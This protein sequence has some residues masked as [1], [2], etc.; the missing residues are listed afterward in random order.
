M[1][2]SWS[3]RHLCTKD[4]I[5]VTLQ[6]RIGML[7]FMAT[8]DDNCV[9]NLGLWDQAFALHWVKDNIAA[10]GGDPDNITVFGQSAGGASVDMLCLS[11]YTRGYLCHSYGESST[12]FFSTGA[13]QWRHIC[14]NVR[15]LSATLTERLLYE[16]FSFKALIK[17]PWHFRF[18][19]LN[20][21][22][23]RFSGIF[24]CISHTFGWLCVK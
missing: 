8:G 3:F 11:P 20:K 9:P 15:F 21:I 12:F 24:S 1:H 16:T 2:F 10:F 13:F 18:N 7:G 5:V 22:L 4:V 6:Y 17:F 23:K 14:M 19:C